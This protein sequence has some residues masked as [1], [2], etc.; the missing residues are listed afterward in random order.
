MKYTN[1]RPYSVPEK[2]T[3]RL[4]EHARAFEP[5]QDGRIAVAIE[6]GWL[7]M[8]ESGTFVRLTQSGSELFA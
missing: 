7:T 2:A 8:H 6:R 4:M 1:E 5:V 3:R